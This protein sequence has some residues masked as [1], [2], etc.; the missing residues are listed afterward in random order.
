V[1]VVV[2]GVTVLDLSGAL[3][4]VRLGPFRV[5]DALWLAILPRRFL[6]LL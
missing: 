2:G 3:V 4:P 1:G 6:F 5:S